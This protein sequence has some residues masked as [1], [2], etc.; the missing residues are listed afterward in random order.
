[1]TL[2]LIASVWTVITLLVVG[3]VSRAAQ[4]LAAPAVEPM[5]VRELLTGE[6]ASTSTAVPS[7]PSV[8][9]DQPLTPAA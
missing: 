4:T 3:F 2:L 8:E 9:H 7:S 5:W 6:R 1:M